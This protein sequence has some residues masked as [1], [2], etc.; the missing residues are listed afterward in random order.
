ME[1]ND[2]DDNNLIDG[3]IN[4]NAETNEIEFEEDIANFMVELFTEYTNYYKHRY[5][6]DSEF[7][8]LTGID[9]IDKKSTNHALDTF[10][11]YFYE[12]QNNE[13]TNPNKNEIYDYDKFKNNQNN[14]ELFGIMKNGEMYKLSS[15]LFSLLIE[16]VNC[17]REHDEKTLFGIV[18]LK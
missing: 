16:L 11:N 5:N 6:K 17:R 15:S 1:N 8:L 12:Y 7:T 13:K 3:L 18:V 9:F 4:Y 14:D 2:T 10:Y